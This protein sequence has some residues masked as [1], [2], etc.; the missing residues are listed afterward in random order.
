MKEL[1]KLDVKG[2]GERKLYKDRIPKRKQFLAVKMSRSD[3]DY[4]RG[5]DAGNAPF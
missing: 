2:K 5:N 4:H 3:E 1:M